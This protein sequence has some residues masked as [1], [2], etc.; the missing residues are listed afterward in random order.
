MKEQLKKYLPSLVYGGSDG[1]VTTFSVMAGAVGAGFD[2]KVV[3]VLG[4]A[5]LFSDGFSM[6][7]ADY[8]AED[9]HAHENKLQALK[10]AIVTFVSFIG[11]GSIP[12]IP[13]LITFEANK[14]TLSIIFTLITFILIGC[15]RAKVLNRNPFHLAF[16]SV[17]I[18]STCAAIAYFIG[19]YIS[20]LI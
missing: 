15:L 13:V 7:S 6:A 10:D 11:I 14:F 1:A 17:A 2:T 3:I 19:N 8:L 9:S 4:L 20:K 18:G 12:L 5:N 16:Q